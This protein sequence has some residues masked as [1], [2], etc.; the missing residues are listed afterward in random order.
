MTSAPTRLAL[1]LALALLAGACTSSDPSGDKGPAATGPP[2]I[3]LDV[4]TEHARQFDDEVPQRLAGSQDELVAASYISGH[5]QQAGY[6]VRLDDVPVGDL[7]E[8][9]NVVALPPGDGDVQFAIVV[10][11][12]TGAG[13][14][15]QGEDLGLFLE[16]AR[17][18]A[19][20]VPDHHVQF[21]ALGAE[22]AEGSGGSLGSRRYLKLL[23]ENDEHPFVISPAVIAGGGFASL[24]PAGDDLNSVAQ[25]LGI[26]KARPLNDPLLASYLRITQMYAEAEIGH[27]IA[28]GGAEE[29]SRVLLE[30][31]SGG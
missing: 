20:R 25:K 19:V 16:L 31:L 8:S 3:Q 26:P 13:V 6:R 28:A 1:A 11:Y 4:V 22:F 18:L 2:E 5:L 14:P 10:P 24:G 29:V 17:A 15:P 7:V 23:Q 9:T 12:G 21:V 27:A 30:F